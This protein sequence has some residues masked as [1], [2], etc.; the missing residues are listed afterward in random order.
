MITSFI[1]NGHTLP[2]LFSSSL[3]LSKSLRN[4]FLSK[5]NLADFKRAIYEDW[6]DNGNIINSS[7][8]YC[9]WTVITSFFSVS[10]AFYN[11]SL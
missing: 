3:S 1:Y 9:F 2:V 7:I 5:V 4:D 6:G 8:A 10:W 11:S